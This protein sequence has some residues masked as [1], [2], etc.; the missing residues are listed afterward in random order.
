MRYDSQLSLRALFLITTVGAFAAAFAR[1]IGLFWCIMIALG[2]ICVRFPIYGYNPI[3]QAV[4]YA[5][6]FLLVTSLTA[7]HLNIQPLEA[8]LP[9]CL[10]PALAYIVGFTNGMREER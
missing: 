6:A 8:L 3:L 4:C 7:Y 1:S 5:M 10:L 2:V 9:C